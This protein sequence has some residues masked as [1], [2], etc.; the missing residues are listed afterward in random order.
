MPINQVATVAN[1]DFG[2]PVVEAQVLKFR[3]RENQ[4]GVISASVENY[5]DTDLVVTV[6]SSPDDVTYTNELGAVTVKGRT[7]KDFTFLVNAS[8]DV[9]VK[10]MASGGVRGC[11]QMRGD[12]ILEAISI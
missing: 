11:V 2:A 5:G 8:T 4:G 7:A 1:Y 10:I 9:F 3:V 6:K 12:S